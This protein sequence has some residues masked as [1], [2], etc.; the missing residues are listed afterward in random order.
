MLY[1]I[2][3]YSMT[4]VCTSSGSGRHP[5]CVTTHTHTQVVNKY[6]DQGIAELVPGVLFIDEVPCVFTCVDLCL[7]VHVW[8]FLIHLFLCEDPFFVHSFTHS[9]IHSI[10]PSPHLTLPHLT[11][12][13][14]TSTHLTSPHLTSPHLT[15]THLTSPH[16]TSPHLHTGAHV[17]S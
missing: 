10:T 11:S 2:K 8:T 4:C 7:H 3:S 12:P 13:H 17:E 16:L 14:L 1:H 5:L 9:F 6:I 15:S